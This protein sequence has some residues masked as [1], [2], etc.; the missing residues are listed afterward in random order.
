LLPRLAALAGLFLHLLDD[1]V[2]AGQRRLRFQDLGDVQPD[3]PTG[4]LCQRALHI[5]CDRLERA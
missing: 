3:A 4:D 1:V 5:V 2:T